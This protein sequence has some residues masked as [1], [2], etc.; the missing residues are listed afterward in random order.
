MLFFCLLYTHYLIFL[1]SLSISLH[2]SLDL[3]E[4]LFSIFFFFLPSQSL[5]FTSW[6]LL[7]YIL[8]TRMIWPVL[9]VRSV[10][11]H[12]SR[13]VIKSLRGLRGSRQSSWLGFASGYWRI[14]I[15]R[16]QSSWSSVIATASCIL[17]SLWRIDFTSCHFKTIPASRVSVIS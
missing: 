10:I 8:R 6:R 12:I 5:I 9:L 7:I 17:M 15:S 3:I 4:D 16:S 1:I 14:S 11:F 2:I 13:L